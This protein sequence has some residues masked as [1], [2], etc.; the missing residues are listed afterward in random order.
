MSEEKWARLDDLRSMVGVAKTALVAAL[1][2]GQCEGKVPG[3]RV[4]ETIDE[5]L[6]HIEA[7]ITQYQCG[8]RNEDHLAHI[9][10]RAAIACAL[11]ERASSAAP[12]SGEGE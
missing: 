3:A 8:D 10:C 6:K 2:D 12:C 9:V 1:E 11:R 7:H 4:S 5:Q